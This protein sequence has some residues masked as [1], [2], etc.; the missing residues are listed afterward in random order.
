MRELIAPTNLKIDFK[1]SEKQYELWQ[2]LQPNF[3]NKCGG[4]IGQRMFGT[5]RNG[6]PQ[7]KPTCTTC[8]NINLPQLILAGGAAGGGKSY[9]ASCWLISS[10]MRFADIRA[11]VARRTLKSLKES[12]FNTIKMVCKDWGLK[13]NVN[14]KINNLEGSLTFWNDS[15]IIMKEIAYAPSDPTYA[16]FGSSEFTICAVDE[17]SECDEKAIEVLFS[18]LRWKTHET[19]MIPKMLLTTNPSINWIR[20]RFVQDDDG[21][22]VECREGELYCPFSVYDNPD[23][24]FRSLYQ[25]SLNKITDKETSE[26]LLYGNWDFVDTNN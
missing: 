12:T 16:R 23:E 25:S 9:L 3:C 4:T 22:P 21:N 18:R 26:R 5:D 20:S 19:F 15:V 17:A 8:G 13:E 24:K 14:Y 7:F 11:V 10:C 6:N 2:S 1:P